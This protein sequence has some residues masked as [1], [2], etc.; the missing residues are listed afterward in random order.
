MN[1]P[2]DSA[3]TV[4]FHFFLFNSYETILLI[5][6]NPSFYTT[7]TKRNL[8]DP[9]HDVIWQESDTQLQMKSRLKMLTDD[10]WMPDAS[11]YLKLT[12]EPTAQVS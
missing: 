7:R 8:Y 2:N 4:N 12:Y 3:E 10:G 11:I 5:D 1:I 6:S 9:V